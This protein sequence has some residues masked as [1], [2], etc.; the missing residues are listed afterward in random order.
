MTEVDRFF[1][2]PSASIREAIACIDRNGKGITLVVDDERHLLG[3]VTDGDIRRA[4][5]HAISLDE[6]VEKV[7]SRQ[8]LVAPPGLSEE[9]ILHLMD[10]GKKTFTVHQ[11]PIVDSTGQVIDL[12]VRSDLVS[13]ELLPVSAVIMAGGL[14]SRLRP[15]TDNTPKPMLPVNGRPLME[16]I[17]EG[18]QQAGIRHI[19]VTTH[20]KAEAISHHFGDGQR[21]GVQIEYVH[22]DKLSGTAG[23]LAL[24]PPWNQPLLVI[25]GDILT[26]VDYR[27]MLHYHQRHQANITVAVREYR[28]EVPY[29][30]VEIDDVMVRKLTEK[31]SLQFFVNAGIY[32]LEP[33]VRGYT[34]KGKFLNM[35]DVIG[36]LL[37]DAKPV[38][39]F[40]VREY[41]I[42]IGQL[43]DY[44]RAQNDMENR[45]IS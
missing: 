15:L 26:R 37:A 28:V 7:M 8:P 38:V 9:E 4:I 42:D 25:N 27:A 23:A 19:I 18:L 31:P 5:L 45:G 1:I 44:D 6:P 39:G 2:P 32:V 24:V 14:G 33:L 30:I 43:A 3:T 29:G 22:E 10:K 35:T 11:L 20:Y 41:W 17:V 36:Y 40:P 34:T 21:F 13:T 12:V 16:W